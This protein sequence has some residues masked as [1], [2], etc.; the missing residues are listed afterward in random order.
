MDGARRRSAEPA[1]PPTAPAW[2]LGEW[3]AV[4]WQVEFRW[5]PSSPEGPLRFGGWICGL[6]GEWVELEAPTGIL[7]GDP[8][9][10]LLRAVRE[11][12]AGAER[13]TL[14]GRT[15]KPS[16]SGISRAKATTST[17]RSLTS[18]GA[19]TSLCSGIRFACANSSERSPL[20]W[21]VSTRTGTCRSSWTSRRT[22]TRQS[23][24]TGLLT[25][26][27][28][29]TSSS[30]GKLVVASRSRVPKLVLKRL[31]LW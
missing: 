9:P 22:M 13:S 14:S 12:T 30:P 18:T 6:G 21:N 4:S 19:S 23:S 10:D 2:H 27:P 17:C 16:I 7:G 25:T 1:S 29:Q 20:R 5:V 31:V 11:I 28:K 24:G 15:N 8:Y 26:R 3:S